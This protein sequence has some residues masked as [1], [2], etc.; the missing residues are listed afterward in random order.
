MGLFLFPA[1]GQQRNQTA[2]SGPHPCPQDN[3]PFGLYAEDLFNA[4]QGLGIGESTLIHLFL[5]GL[6]DP[7]NWEELGELDT[8]SYWEMVDHVIYLKEMDLLEGAPLPVWAVVPE[9]PRIVPATCRF[10][11]SFFGCP[12]LRRSMED[13]LLMSVKQAVAAH[14]PPKAAV[15]AHKAPEVAGSAP[16]RELSESSPEPAP[17]LE[18]MQSA[19]EP[20]PVEAKEAAAPTVVADGAPAP[21]V[22]PDEAAASRSQKRRRRRKKGSSTLQGLEAVPEPSAGQEAVPEPLQL[23]ALPAPPMR[24]ALPAP[25]K[26]LAL[27]APP[28]RL[29]LPAPPKRLALPA[30]P[31]RLAL[32]APPKRLSLPA[33]PK[34]LALPAP[35]KRLALP[36][37]PKRLALPAPPKRLALPGERP[38]L[39]GVVSGFCHF[40]LVLFMVL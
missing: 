37:P 35:P 2:A 6:D 40:G 13:T 18:P 36:E 34:R 7:V 14:G 31:K 23:L 17:F 4:A 9:P 22:A 3:R 11:G 33:P 26:R 16:F 27:P 20:A 19:P 5:A 25:P 30:P 24:L 1:P 10:S 8:W 39:G 28:K 12:G 32:P 29:A 15:S 38:F 21:P